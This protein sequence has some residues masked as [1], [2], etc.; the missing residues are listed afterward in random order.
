MRLTMK[1]GPKALFCDSYHQ[2]AGTAS[3]DATVT[4]RFLEKL[5][6]IYSRGIRTAI[7]VLLSTHPCD[8]MET[9]DRLTGNASVETDPASSVRNGKAHLVYQRRVERWRGRSTVRS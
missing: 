3:R 5:V 7:M 8:P 6:W 2:P 9:G 1:P 4:E